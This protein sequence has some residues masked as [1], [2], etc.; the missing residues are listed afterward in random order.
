MRNHLWM[1]RKFG[2]R[3]YLRYCRARRAGIIV[4]YAQVPW[5]RSDD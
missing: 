2:L 3:R 4:D 5:E 1:I